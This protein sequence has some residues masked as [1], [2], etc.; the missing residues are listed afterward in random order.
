MVKV[1]LPLALTLF[2]AACVATAGDPCAGFT[3]IRPALTDA[4]TMSPDLARQILAHNEAGAR[5][6]Q[7]TP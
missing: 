3:P 7:W 2:V 5:L 6:C 1:A 4:A